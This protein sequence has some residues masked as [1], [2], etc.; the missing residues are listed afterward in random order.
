MK[1]FLIIA[2]VLIPSSLGTIEMHN[3]P[4]LHQ[5]RVTSAMTYHGTPFAECIESSCTFERDGQT[6]NLFTQATEQWLN[7]LKGERK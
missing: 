5:W 2:V 4:D 7:K 1:L 3:C 6:I